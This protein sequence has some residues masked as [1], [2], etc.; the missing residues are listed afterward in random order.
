MSLTKDMLF[1]IVSDI[2]GS[3]L[4]D[5]LLVNKVIHSFKAHLIY[6]YRDVMM[7]NNGVSRIVMHHVDNYYPS[8][9]IFNPNA[10]ISMEY[11]LRGE[12]INRS[13]PFIT[14]NIQNLVLNGRI[15]D[16][17][18]PLVNLFSLSLILDE[19]LDGIY[20]L[21][22]LINLTKLS[23]SPAVTSIEGLTIAPNLETMVIGNIDD[24]IYNL[25][26][27]KELVFIECS[28]YID[29]TKFKKLVNITFDNCEINMNHKRDIHK[30]YVSNC[31]NLDLNIYSN[32][33]HIEFN[34]HDIE[35]IDCLTE[36]LSIRIDHGIS[37]ALNYNKLT[38]C[39]VLDLYG[40]S[41]TNISTLVNLTKLCLIGCDIISDISNLPNLL[42]LDAHDCETL[43]TISNLPRLT[44]LNV[45][46]TQVR[47]VNEFI[48]LKKLIIKENIN[49][50]DISHLVN[51][52][53]LN[54]EDTYIATVENHKKL[55]V[56][57]MSS[58]D[59]ENIDGLY[60]I[61]KLDAS[62]TI[63]SNVKHL[64]NL[65]K[66]KCAKSLIRDLTGLKN[67]RVLIS[68]AD[69]IKSMIGLE[70]VYDI[71]IYNR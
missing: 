70:F 50:M 34:I 64:L 57:K 60:D 14:K 1:S 6:K 18:I 27:V 31:R 56:L 39:Y 71:C 41:V 7:G 8:P 11:V 28:N 42:Y 36:V 22:N 9:E 38:K 65:R 26:N 25:I 48:S 16:T 62:N 23:I 61:I 47:S 66:L 4:A 43:L 30:L 37:P 49:I 63:I 52:E 53:Y 21:N 69:E 24:T 19:E 59:V 54:I 5:V 35:S 10:I 20:K 3:D 46:N 51:L 33:K 17:Y 45:S 29:L 15:L 58:T 13:K 68:S 44:Y 32:I 55:K 12:S 67:I 40:Q 2:T